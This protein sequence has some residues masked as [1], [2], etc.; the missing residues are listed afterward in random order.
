VEIGLLYDFDLPEALDTTPLSTITP[1]V[2]L[3]ADHPLAGQS[4]IKDADLHDM[5]IISIA[6]DVS[7]EKLEGELRMRG[8]E[9]KVAS[10]EMMGA[11]LG[12]A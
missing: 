7:C 1:Y 3:A 12:M 4:A 2:L 6:E 5:P 10:L 9:P 8:I 11:W